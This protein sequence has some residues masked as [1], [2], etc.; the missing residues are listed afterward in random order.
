MTPE[1]W[2]Q[3]KRLFDA[4][5]QRDA[6][7]R[8]S[9]LSQACGGDGEL[10]KEVE[11]LLAA[12]EQA[13][14]FMAVS[15]TQ[16][17][18]AVEESVPASNAVDSFAG[19]VLSHYRVEA[20][21]GSGGMG[22]VY[23][24]TDLKLGR[25]VAIKLL[26][27]QFAASGDAKARFLREARAA[28]ALDHPNIGAIYELG[29][30]DGELFIAMALY[31]GETLKQRLE[32]GPL[33]VP[34]A[35]DALRQV[36][37]GLEAAHRAA[38]VHRDIKPAN[39]LIT[40]D[41]TIKILDFG[42]AK[43]VSDSQAQTMT[44]AG[45]AMGTLLYMSPEQL[46]GEPVDERS[47]LW[48]LGVVA[49]E[50]LARV[51][52]FQTDS[53]AASAA[54]ILHDEPV[55][56]AAIPGIP[57][58]LAQLV[59]QLL[60]KRPAQRPQSVSEV[61]QR[62]EHRPHP[63]L[64]MKRR[65]FALLRALGI[66]A[67]IIGAAGL[68][69]Y[70]QRGETQNQARAIKSLVVL[71]FV[72]DS[73]NADMEYLSDGIAETLIDN[74]SQIP[75][76]QVI[77]RNTAFRYK[78]KDVDF[79]RLAREL[80]VG[81]VVTG[82]VQQRGDTLVVRADLVN[83]G[84]GSEL[85]G[86]KYNRKL[87]DLLAVEAEIATA[88]SE[89][90]RPRLTARMQ[91]RVAKRNTN[92]EAFQV[93]LRGRYFWNKRTKEAVNQSLEYFQR[94]T[95]LDP[96][97]ALAYAGLADAYGSLAHLQYARTEE[98]YPKAEAA[99]LKALA[100]DEEL[101]EAHAALGYI[102]MTQWDWLTTEKECKR[103]IALNPSYALAHSW[104]GV[105]LLRMARFEDAAAEFTQALQLDPA[106]VAYIGNLGWTFCLSGQYER[107]VALIK[108]EIRMAPDLPYSHLLLGGC[109]L[110][111]KMYREAIDE[112]KHG[113]AMRGTDPRFSGALAYA[114]ARSGNRDG[115]LTIL[116]ELKERDSIEDVATVIAD[117]YAG[118]DDRDHAFE[119]L[120]KAYRRRSS[121]LIPIKVDPALDALRSDPRFADL[122]HR[123]G[124]PP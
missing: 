97:Y 90:L 15:S 91:Q 96:D 84:T 88:I 48:S 19:R 42:L 10:Q 103:A 27:R 75:E 65:R 77:A 113:M 85:W 1:H 92:S 38:I 33:T 124:L 43:L 8:R 40:T 30:Q 50:V 107:G 12:H 55:S 44:K 51:S 79:Q 122:V 115:A 120:E 117:A 37:L 83:L 108:E 109:Y 22:V 46:R 68:Y 49:Y 86:E 123:M 21:L 62:L 26:S 25:A 82:R 41:G 93:Y 13:G 7:S 81:A 110:R 17:S 24:A 31:E 80:S 47:D 111:M 52:P 114:Y 73:A 16:L 54:R 36:A 76:L 5:L 74:L 53:S 3:V 121:T 58:W 99:A 57:D 101:P 70:F 6:V 61:R 28:S 9:F 72:S 104:Y 105:L 56:L 71:P 23:R 39:V 4:A 102:K 89:K 32:K 116:S 95:E 11:K 66:A 87:T 2:Q 34:E 60:Q 98:V 18:Q 106:S 45:Q 35:V 59:S 67:A 118:L 69:V 94:A 100:L 119:W 63:S 112:L 29:E 78:G 14:S 64:E 20:R